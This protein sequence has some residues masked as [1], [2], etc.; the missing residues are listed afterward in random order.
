MRICN[1]LKLILIFFSTT[2]FAADPV[3]IS[4]PHAY[5]NIGKHVSILKD[6]HNSFTLEQVIRM[7]DAGKFV[8][9][10]ESIL[11][12][13]N[14]TSAF[15]IKIRYQNSSKQNAY[16][17]VDVPN[18]DYIDF[19]TTDDKGKLIH[20]H[21][22]TLSAPNLN[23][24]ATNQYIFDLPQTGATDQGRDVY[25]KV[26]TD[27]IMLLALKI[28]DAKSLISSGNYKVG[29]ESVYSGI[30]IMLFVFNIF[31]FISVKDRTYLYYSIYI[32]ALFIYV[33]LYIRGHGYILG[34]D[35]RKFLNM[36]PHVFASLATLAAYFF[37]W[38]FLGIKE[39]VPKLILVYKVM[40]ILWII[41]F[42]IAIFG[43]KS[44]LAVLVNYLSF[45]SCIV[46][47]YAGLCAYRKGLKP[48][49]YYLIAWFAVGI[50]F[51]IA[52]LGLT[53]VIPY[54][55][56]SYEV[57][58]IGTTIEMLFLS[59][60]LGDRFNHI[61]QEKKRVEKENLKL[62]LL[63]NERLEFV[64]EERTQKLSK[65]N[66]EKD[67][68]FSIVAHDLRSPF[69]SLVSILELNDNDMLD[70][71]E[72]KML[73]QETRKNVDQ[74]HLTLNN[75]LYWA[76]GQMEM[77]GSN[78][79]NFDLGAMAEKL[80]LVYQP[81]SISKKVKLVTDISGTCNVFADVNEINLVLRNLI[82]NA[83]KFSPQNSVINIMMKQQAGEVQVSVGNVTQE[84]ITNKLEALDSQE[85]FSTP[86]TNNE[87]G[88]GLGLHLCREYIHLNGGDMRVVVKD[89]QI[90][91]SFSLPAFGDMKTMS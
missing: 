25:L 50:S 58:P 53:G 43:G 10:T 11:N 55:D 91:I 24:V 77:P 85:F 40:I 1:V 76:K 56:L 64:V 42:I 48:A 59:F 57:G 30:L 28:A 27:N 44:I 26:R 14:S 62:I 45:I 51:I 32:A 7:G 89:H 74:I 87:Q 61:R 60:A 3:M 52:L 13:G 83:L 49:L 73:L 69:N 39:R 4:V 22:G 29:F 20:Q 46:A 36:Y 38:Q 21:T 37:S 63:H 6:Q 16:L 15:W 71:E 88:I 84:D 33:V 68:L 47:W 9:S 12:L 79:E 54:Y 72:L 82:D 65:A 5:E 90:T 80:I 67:K 34:P 23:V 66:A 41:L 8:R 17:I 2:V 31:L 86:G 78:P 75:L 81:L 18:I 19:Y 35:F 70:F